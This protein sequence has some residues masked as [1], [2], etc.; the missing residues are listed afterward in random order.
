V[1][2]G[3]NRLLPAVAQAH[4]LAV[5]V[6]VLPGVMRDDEPG[7]AAVEEANAAVHFFV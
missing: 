5:A 3:L 7:E 1:L 4:P 6:L 2:V